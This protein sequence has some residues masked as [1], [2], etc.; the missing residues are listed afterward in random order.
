MRLF[1]VVLFLAT[2]FNVSAQSRADVFNKDVPFTYF[3]IDLS[4]AKLIGD[5]GRYGSES[6]MQRLAEAWN[7]L[8][9]KE[10]AKF[11]VAK[12]FGRATVTNAIEVTKDHN[13]QLEILSHYTDNKDEA[14][15]LTFNDVKRIV[16]GYDFGGASGLGMMFIVDSFS[17][18]HG[19]AFVWVT[20]INIDRKEVVFTERMEG[21]PGGAGLRNFWANSLHDILQ[22]IQKKEFKKWQKANPGL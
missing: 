9:L 7:D 13:V 10:P 22:Q 20:F 15:R 1:I 14:Q 16:G 18:P 5:R 21:N 17:K 2:A 19:K 4:S 11:D 12:P 3:G 6:D 8:F